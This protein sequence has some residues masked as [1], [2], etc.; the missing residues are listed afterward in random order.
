MAIS[1]EAWS[2]ARSRVLARSAD[3]A[4]R[5]AADY[6]S[7][8]AQFPD[9]AGYLEQLAA[10]LDRYAAQCRAAAADPSL[11]TPTYAGTHSDREG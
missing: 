11:P 1:A 5:T 4:A 7:R 10:G 9:D 3:A 2:A 8:V 6:R